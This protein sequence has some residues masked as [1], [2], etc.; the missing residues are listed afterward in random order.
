MMNG[1]IFLFSSLA[2]PVP[3]TQRKTKS[4]NQKSDA[5]SQ[6]VKKKIVGRQRAAIPHCASCPLTASCLYFSHGK[7]V[8]MQIMGEIMA[9]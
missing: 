6:V 9:E 8:I 2:L 7:H 3:H 1:F 4:I 5:F